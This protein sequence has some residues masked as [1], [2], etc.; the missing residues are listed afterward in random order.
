MNT[1]IFFL[2]CTFSLL[3]LISIAQDINPVTWRYSAKK[4]SGKTFEIHIIA[5]IDPPWHVYSQDSPEEISLPT[6]IKFMPNPL[7]QLE[8]E[9]KVKGLKIEKEDAISGMKLKYYADKVEFIQ[10]INL[11]ANI[12]T[13]LNGNINFM[14]CNE[15][16]CLPPTDQKFSIS[17]NTN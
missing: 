8:G 7:I 5:Y 15:K 16:Q 2:T 17:I 9:L 1:K 14:T 3:V 6:K 13:N 10:T 4:I 11:K 12:K